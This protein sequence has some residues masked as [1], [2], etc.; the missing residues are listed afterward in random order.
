MSVNVNDCGNY[1][2]IEFNEYIHNGW[3]TV[4]CITRKVDLDKEQV[5]SI[6]E[7]LIEWLKKQKDKD[8]E[9]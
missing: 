2:V 7:K 1:V 4:G 3:A 9:Q 5:E 6:V 8:N